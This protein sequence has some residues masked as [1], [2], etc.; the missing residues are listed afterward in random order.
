MGSEEHPNRL[1]ECRVQ[2]G[3][4]QEQLSKETGI[5]RSMIAMIESHKRDMSIAQIL[6]LCDVLGVSADELL[7]SWYYYAVIRMEK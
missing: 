7:G 3:L 2:A 1:R 4:T 6:T 5:S